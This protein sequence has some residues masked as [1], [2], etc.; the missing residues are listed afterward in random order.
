ML[1]QEVLSFRKWSGIYF[2][3][4]LNHF[5]FVWSIDTEWPPSSQNSLVH[6]IINHD[7]FSWLLRSILSWVCVTHFSFLGWNQWIKILRQCLWARSQSSR[8]YLLVAVH[9]PWT[10]GFGKSRQCPRLL[11]G[12]W[13][14]APC[15]GLHRWSC[16]S[17]H[18]RTY[19]SPLG[20]GNQGWV[21]FHIARYVPLPIRSHQY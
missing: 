10:E 8:Y 16:C 17:N 19:P 5:H 20:R 2:L 12:C 6:S 4:I 15:F 21:D 9:P 7:G 3:W 13:S 11:W 1:K 18:A 14:T